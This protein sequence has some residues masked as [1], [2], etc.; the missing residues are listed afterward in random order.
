MLVVS[1]SGLSGYVPFDPDFDFACQL[2]FPLPWSHSLL[3][4]FLFLKI[5]FI[6]HTGQILA[7]HR[8]W[9]VPK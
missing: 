9:D 2:N 1:G 6:N 5:V 8:K 4:P 7:S 3:L